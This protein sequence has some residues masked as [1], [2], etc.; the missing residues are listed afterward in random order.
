LPALLSKKVHKINDDEKFRNKIHYITNM[1]HADSCS[2][3]MDAF[4]GLSYNKQISINMTSFFIH[5]PFDKKAILSDSEIQAVMN[6]TEQRYL[7]LCSVRIHKKSHSRS[8]F[9]ELHIFVDHSN[10]TS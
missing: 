1:G 3:E 9:Q 7:G 6:L 5:Y 8:G 2:I 4:I 10:G